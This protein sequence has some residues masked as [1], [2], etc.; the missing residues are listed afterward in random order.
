VLVSQVQRE[1]HR[2]LPAASMRSD[3][4]RDQNGMAIALFCMASPSCKTADIQ[5]WSQADA[6][7]KTCRDGKWYS[8]IFPRLVM[9]GSKYCFTHPSETGLI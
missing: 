7:D 5:L 4:F 2:P 1:C 3:L 9:C 6:E 8:H